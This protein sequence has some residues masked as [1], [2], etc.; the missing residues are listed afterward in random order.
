MNLASSS[1]VSRSF[2]S[3]C[4]M[5]DFPFRPP[6]GLR[7]REQSMSTSRFSTTRPDVILYRISCFTFL[8]PHR[9]VVT[10]AV[11]GPRKGSRARDPYI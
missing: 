4:L 1:T 3:T 6:L 10:L 8:S 11:Q 2:R 5:V 7:V 9:M